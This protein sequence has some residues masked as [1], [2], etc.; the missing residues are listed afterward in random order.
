MRLWTLNP[1]YLDAQGLTALWRESLLA[2]TVL[3]GETRGYT[4]H[5]Q[6]LRFQALADPQGGIERYLHVIHEESLARGYRFDAG[7]L[8]SLQG[9]IRVVATSGQL[10]YEWRHLLDKLRA[11]RP[12]LFAKWQQLPSPE[13]HAMFDVTTGP[14]ETWE[15]T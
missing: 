6:L 2:R 13:A 15:R 8:G 10:A 11:R 4:R 14:V 9:D 3:R 5:P 7:K 1:C 12:V